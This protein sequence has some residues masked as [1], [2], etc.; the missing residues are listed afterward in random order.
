MEITKIFKKIAFIII[1]IIHIF[2]FLLPTLIY[3]RIIKSLTALK[4]S[5]F[6]IF[7]TP[8]HWIFFNDRCVLDIIAGIFEKKKLYSHKTGYYHRNLFFIIKPLS[9]YLNLSI[10]D[11][12]E[13]LCAVVLAYNAILIWHFIFF[14]NK[15]KL[16]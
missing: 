8:L 7:F 13:K 5:F 1:E 12:I 6:L 10:Q 3:F 15:C 11:T 2:V 14:K 4:I 16:K 9:R